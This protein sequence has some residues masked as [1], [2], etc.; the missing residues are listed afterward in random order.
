MFRTSLLIIAFLFISSNLQANEIQK[1]DLNIA[2]KILFPSKVLNEQREISI[3]TPENYHQDKKYQVIYVLDGEFHFIPTVGIVNSLASIGEIPDSIVVGI[4]TSIRVRD[5]LP[6][7]AN[8]PLSNQQQWIQQQFP[9]FGKTKNFTKFLATELFPYIENNYSTLANRTIIGHSNAGVYALHTLISQPELFTNYL[10]ISP[11]PW[12]GAEEIDNFFPQQ[13]KANSVP[14]KNLFLTVAGEGGRYYSNTM[15]II[16]NLES[17]TQSELSWQ[18]KHLQDKTHETTIFPSIYQ[19]LST[20]Y[21]DFYF[22]QIEVT[23]KYGQII[24]VIEYYE[25]LSKKYQ[26]EVPIPLSV[27]AE[28][29]NLQL[30]NNREQQA[31]ETLKIFVNLYPESAYSYQNLAQAYMR[32]KQYALAKSSFSQ[33]LTIAKEKNEVSYTVIDYLE[34]M[35]KQ[36]DSQL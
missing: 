8:K 9:R 26:F 34:D 25:D 1:I 20:L 23:A 35:I 27:L 33:A 28:L 7:I 30:S 16:A 11:A 3:Y 22:D 6:P 19:G 24:D 18:F 15:R 13:S 17:S 5:Y 32:T 14:I 29:A 10:V 12:W 36:A 21:K 31:F 2:K 4:K